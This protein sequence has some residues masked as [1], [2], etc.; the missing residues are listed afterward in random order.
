MATPG[1]P[2]PFGA[3]SGPNTATPS[4]ADIDPG[5]RLLSRYLEGTRRIVSLSAQQLP[6]LTP[7]ECQSLSPG[8]SV[9]LVLLCSTIHALNSIGLQVDELQT[10]MPDHGSQ[11]AN[12]LIGL[13][14][15]DLRNSVSHLSR[16]VVHPVLRPTP[17]STV[18][19]PPSNPTSGRP[20]R[21]SAPLPA[22]PR[23]TTPLQRA[24]PLP[25]RSYA[26]V[27]HG[28]TSDFDQ[29][30]AANAATRRGKGKGK[31]SPPT[32]TASKVASV[33]EASSL[34]GPPPLTS[35]AR[36]FYAPRNIPAPD[37]ERDLI[38][39]RWPDLAASVLREANSG[40][41]GS[42]KVFVNGNGRVSLTVIDTSVPAA[43]Y[44]AFFDA[45]IHKL[46][47]FFPVGDNP[48]MPFRLA[49]TDLQ[50]AIHGLPIKAHPEADPALCDLLQPSIFN[51]QSVLISKARFLNP[52]RASRLHDK[53]AFSVVVQ[54]PAED[55]KSLTDLSR[56][57]ILSGNYVIKRAYPS[58]PSNQC[59]NCCRFGHVKP[60]CKKPTICPLCAG[61]HAKT[62]HR[63]PNPT[64]PRG[65]NL[66]PVLNCCIASPGRCPNCSEDHSASYRDCT[67]RTVPPSRIAPDTPEAED[68][69]PPV[70]LRPPQPASPQLPSTDT[71]AMDIQPDE[72]GL[73]TLS[74]IPPPQILCP[75]WSLLPQGPSSCCA[76]GPLG[77]HL[78]DWSPPTR[79]G[80]QPLP[81]PQSSVG[82]TP[83]NVSQFILST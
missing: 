22:V 80:A 46:N 26:E 24:V 70:L 82:L 34:K 66:K 36:R 35:A 12:S 64:C 20:N 68:A 38:R 50:S 1:C 73:P 27:I 61:P 23:D 79:W 59:N 25:T 14:I 43:S 49:P 48:W 10:R 58:S 63:C 2:P 40:L 45:L 53:E 7:Q 30:V 13:E 75:R 47:Q 4:E 69:A 51:S 62:E 11:V 9:L 54:V 65:G 3:P 32:T 72:T 77:I 55:G 6:S 28:G 21:P 78:Q 39:I 37:P 19:P 17:S 67:A 5:A 42:F 81:C 52:D 44:S 57:P 16:R 18:P 41:P 33:V 83:V 29:A 15:R 76:H 8:E 74:S 60:R 71:D 56:I 31:K